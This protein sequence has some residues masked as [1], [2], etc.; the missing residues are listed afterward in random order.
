MQKNQRK[1][2]FISTV[3]LIIIGLAVIGLLGFS[4]RDAIANE[5]VQDNF[6]FV[7]DKVTYV[8]DNYLERPTS[9]AIDFLKSVLWEASSDTLENLE[10]GESLAPK[11]AIPQVPN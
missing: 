9:A 7:W 6:A 4:I 1:R 2:G 8:W 11:D 5:T 3:I 10:A